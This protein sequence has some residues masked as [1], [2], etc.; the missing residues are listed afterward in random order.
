MSARSSA[1]PALRVATPWEARDRAELER[2]LKAE[3]TGL[4]SLRIAWVELPPGTP[5]DRARAREPAIDVFLGGP[6]A[7]YARLAA[8]GSLAPPGG[9]GQPH[10]R[11]VRRSAIRPWPEEPGRDPSARPLLDDPRADPVTLAWARGTLERGPWVEGYAALIASYGSAARPAG[12]LAGS[13][14]AT[15]EHAGSRS[16]WTPALV[17]QETGAG[18]PILYEEAG[19]IAAGSTHPAAGAF[20]DF[21]AARQTPGDRTRTTSPDPVRDELLADLLGSTLVDA[22]DELTAAWR[23]VEAGRPSDDQARARLVEPPPWPPAFVNKLQERGGDRALAMVQ[24]LASRVSPEPEARLWLV[25]SWLRPSRPIDGSLLAELSAAA[26]GR[27]A[28]QTAFRDW[29][30]G[31]WTAWARQRYRRVAR[32]VA[33]QAPQPG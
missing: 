29:L 5:F 27:L 10:F 30:R 11:I 8:A 17:G 32:L 14:R 9:E 12:W 25:Q 13:A 26:D 33:G 19:G 23:A 1:E 21:L 7:E 31:E 15:V 16:L 24:D 28:R 20:L 4:E 6:I 2:H 3:G 22:Q 18:E